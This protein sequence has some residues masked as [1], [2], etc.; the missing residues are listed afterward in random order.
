MVAMVLVFAC[1]N[2]T[3]VEAAEPAGSNTDEPAPAEDTTSDPS[4]YVVDDTAAVEAPEL[5]PAQVG[6]AIEAAIAA[7]RGMN[8]NDIA[9]A[10]ESVWALRDDG[11]CPY[12]YPEYLELYDQYIWYDSCTASSG[13][14][15]DGYGYYTAYHD[16]V[17]SYYTY[18]RYFSLY[19]SP[20]NLTLPNGETLTGSGT[21]YTY[22]IDYWGYG[23]RASNATIQGTWRWDGATWADSW[24][25]DGVSIDIE[26]TGTQYLSGATYTSINGSLADINEQ[27]TA[28]NFDRLYLM[29]EAAGTSCSAEPG[30]T[31][32]I[33]DAAGSWYDVTFSGPAYSGAP[34]FPA[35]C[36]GCVDVWWRGENLGETCPDTSGLVNW[37]G[38]PWN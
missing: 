26:F 13:A 4:P 16:Y 14:T 30:G 8:P 36:D 23:Y 22:D 32:R 1:S 31:I 29:N 12:Y 7:I 38:R 3:G 9:D 18:D 5:S 25:G 2:E 37:E 34:S 24:L 10:Y 11:V 15:F 20:V 19:G 28:V 27:I 17:G 33:R 21:A 6:E 35:Y